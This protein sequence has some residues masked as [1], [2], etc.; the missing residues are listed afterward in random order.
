MNFENKLK[1]M[2]KVNF[3]AP[4]VD[5]FIKKMHFEN[6]CRDIKRNNFISG[7]Y[8]AITILTLGLFTI[9]Q[10]ADDPSFHAS[11]DLKAMEFMDEETELYVYDLAS[12]LVETSDDIWKTIDFLNEIKFEPIIALSYGE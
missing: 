12:Y 8:S 10:L 2:A 9:S 7:I 3:K 6:K 5:F 1:N 11:Y 4:D